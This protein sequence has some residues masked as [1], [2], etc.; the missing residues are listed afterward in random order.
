MTKELFQKI[1]IPKERFKKHCLSPKDFIAK[2]KEPGYKVIDIRDWKLRE[3]FPISLPWTK[4]EHIPI[5][6]FCTLV[7]KRSRKV[8]R[9]KLLIMDKAGKL[10]R[11][12]QY[13]LEDAG[14]KNYYFL[15]GG[16]E[17][18]RKEGYDQHG[19]KK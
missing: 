10:V 17:R 6:R 18:W 8:T 9:K 3:E 15:D 14:L 16:V 4:V 11:W 5:N 13:V 1:W 19:H 2:S 7:K 12:V